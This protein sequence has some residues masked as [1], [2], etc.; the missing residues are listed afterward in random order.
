MNIEDARIIWGTDLTEEEL[1]EWTEQVNAREKVYHLDDPGV[2][3]G[4]TICIDADQKWA[5]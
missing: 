1:R 2:P 5:K 3:E 4:A